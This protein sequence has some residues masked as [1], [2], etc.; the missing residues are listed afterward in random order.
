MLVG[1]ELAMHLSA[2]PY[3]ARA[4]PWMGRDGRSASTQ[5]HFRDVKHVAY[6]VDRKEYHTWN[7]H[8]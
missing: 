5:Y 1:V 3:R 2:G 6:S 7:T 8:Q 4:T